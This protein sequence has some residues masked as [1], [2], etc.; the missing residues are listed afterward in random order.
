MDR[1]HLLETMDT[2]RDAPIQEPLTEARL[3]EAEDELSQA[4]RD[5]K[6]GKAYLDSQGH[7]RLR[8]KQEYQA[9]KGKK[10][11]TGKGPRA[12]WSA[13]VKKEFP[14]NLDFDAHAAKKNG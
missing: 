14:D 11:W 10:V 12:S 9:Y 1:K 8:Q 4:S 5:W 3:S 2:R 7:Y 6:S 13:A